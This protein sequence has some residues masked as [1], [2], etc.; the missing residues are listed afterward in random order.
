[1]PSETTLNAKNLAGLGADRLAELLLELAQGDAAAK[2]ALRMELASRNGGDVGAEIR[3]RLASIAKSRSFVDWRRIRELAN[4]LDMQRAAIM[5]HVAPE[6]PGEA[7]DLLWRMLEMAPKIY[8]R[9]DDSNGTIGTVISTALDDLGIVAGP[10]NLEK[11]KLAERVFEGVCGNDYGQ[12]DGLIAL[13]AGALG[14]QGLGLLKAKFEELAARPPI[15]PNKDERRIIAYG[16]GGPIYEDDFEATHHARLVKHALTDIAD[17][18]GDVDGYIARFSDEDRTN[19]AIAAGI[20]ERLLGVQRAEEAMAVLTGAEATSQAGGHWPDWLRVKIDV[21]EALGRMDEAQ[22]ERW[23]VFERTLSS[24][25][26]RSYL[27]R[28]P[29]FDDVDAERKALAHVQQYANFHHALWFLVGWPSYELAA[30]LVLARHAE[31]DGNN[32]GLL[33]PAAEALE[34]NYPLAATLMLRAMIGYSLD[35]AKATRYG[36]AA[37]HMQ[38]CEY[39]AKRIESF[40][41]HADHDAFVAGL[42]LRHGRKSG[43]WNAG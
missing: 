37:R 7:F 27:K 29:D 24:E 34:Q 38:S 33:T 12:F 16:S 1:M 8:E 9:C 17:A 32:Y 28:L 22:A 19:P 11:G 2:R 31:I 23:A 26:V 18:L 36:H 30:E 15:K 10:A 13:M 39:L 25:Y 4:D 35:K 20:A 6:K 43:F 42:R 41:D 5:A 21:L 3:K 14:Q 40:G